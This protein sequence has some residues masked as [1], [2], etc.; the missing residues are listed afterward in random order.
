[1]SIADT[2]KDIAAESA[3]NPAEKKSLRLIAK[4]IESP[5]AEREPRL[6]CATTRQLLE[7]ITARI[8]V[9]GEL[10]YRTIDSH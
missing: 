9:N 6:G 4:E 7:E 1:M 3:L 2:P 10:D 8:E 5:Q